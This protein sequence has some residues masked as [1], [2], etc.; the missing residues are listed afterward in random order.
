MTLGNQLSSSN[1]K[2]II[3]GFLTVTIL[4]FIGWGARLFFDR[5]GSVLPMQ[6]ESAHT[7]AV[8]NVSSSGNP[9]QWVEPLSSS[10]ELNGGAG[11]NGLLSAT[12]E[13]L[14]E[15]LA[16][17]LTS[18]FADAVDPTQGTSSAVLIQQL[19]A[20]QINPQAVADIIKNAGV[21][22]VTSVP[23]D[24]FVVIQNPSRD[25]NNSYAAVHSNVLV[26]I[27]AAMEDQ[28]SFQDALSDA[29]VNGKTAAL[30][31]I[32]GDLNG[33]LQELNGA[34]VPLSAQKAYTSTWLAAKNFSLLLESII[35]YKDDPVRLY[36]ILND[37]FDKA[38]Q[39]WNTAVKETDAWFAS[40]N[41]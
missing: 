19:S 24:N 9:L 32:D 6:D 29:V 31:K 13:N 40:I 38:A 5:V 8:S 7:P 3:A 27:N 33:A 22:F 25:D 21:P 36:A 18:Q 12:N 16:S 35:M 17:N 4:F 28:Q 37:G 1:N 34:R 39:Y 2:Q 26:K 10:S 11:I 30:S 14:T 15:K 20:A 23:A 41:K